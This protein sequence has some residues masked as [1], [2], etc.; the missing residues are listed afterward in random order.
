MLL[1]VV[2]AVLLACTVL[3]GI[4][5]SML[6]IS[7]GPVDTV[8]TGTGL[9][10]MAGGPYAWKNLRGTALHAAASRQLCCLIRPTVSRSR[11]VAA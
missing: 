5:L 8:L 6:G 10:A 1:S 9:L 11:I 2:A 7:F 3:R 4:D